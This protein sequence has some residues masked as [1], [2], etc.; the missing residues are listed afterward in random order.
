MRFD[1]IQRNA[2]RLEERLE[3]TNLVEPTRWN[4][5]RRSRSS[6]SKCLHFCIRFIRRH[7]HDP[8]SET[9]LVRETG[10]CESDVSLR[11]H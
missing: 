5:S 9:R 4:M 11:E 1:V 6:R 8:P 10:I 3:G 7:L 2:R